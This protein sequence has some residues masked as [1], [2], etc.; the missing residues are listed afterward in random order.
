GTIEDVVVSLRWPDGFI[1]IGPS[2]GGITF[3][4]RIDFRP[5][6]VRVGVTSSLEVRSLPE[7]LRAKVGGELACLDKSC[8]SFTPTHPGDAFIELEY[9]TVSGDRE[10]RNIGMVPVMP[11]AF[12]EIPASVDVGRS[13]QVIIR[14]L[15]PSLFGET[16][17]L[18]VD[19]K[20]CDQWI[21]DSEPY[22]W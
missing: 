6:P 21:A 2:I 13:L 4:P 10:W 16:V 22:V 7:P 17:S 18:R 3:E 14:D 12:V 15:E 11:A 8:I 1:Q 20:A 19:S 9:R 5:L